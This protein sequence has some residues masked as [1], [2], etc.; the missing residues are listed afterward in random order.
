MYIKREV[1][2][3]AEKFSVH[4]Y[5]KLNNNFMGGVKIGI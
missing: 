5:S 1:H 3:N 2:S 4:C